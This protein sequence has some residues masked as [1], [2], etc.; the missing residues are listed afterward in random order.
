[1]PASRIFNNIVKTG[2]WPTRWKEE[3]GIPLNKVKPKQPKNEEELRVISLT[4][5]LSKIFES[6]IMDLLL[7]IVGP[8]IDL[9]QYGGLKGNSCS[10]Y[11]IDLVTFILYNQDLKEPKAVLAAMVDFEKA[12]NRQNHNK[13]ITILHDLGVPG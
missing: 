8:K 10:H 2:A 11:L 1:M 7:K 3:R 13:L 9:R 4:P 6:I 12:F 5:F